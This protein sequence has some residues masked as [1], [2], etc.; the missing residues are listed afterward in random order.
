MWIHFTP[1]PQPISLR[2]SLIPS[3]HLRLVFQVVF[4]FG[5]SRQNPAQVSPLYRACHMPRPPHSP[6]FD[7]LDDIWWWVQITKLPIVQLSPFSRYFIPL[8]SKY[9]PSTLF[10]DTPALIN[11]SICCNSETKLGN[12]N[13]LR[14]EWTET[15][16]I[17]VS[18]RVQLV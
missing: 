10:S 4:S 14:G 6:W 8:R 7:L 15:G 11:R 18:E 2:S 5:L 9:S 17:N 13:S 3:S 1:P 12:P 16:S